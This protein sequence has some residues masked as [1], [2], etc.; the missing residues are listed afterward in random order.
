MYDLD[1]RVEQ[2]EERKNQF[3][4]I[5][6]SS[7]AFPWPC[8]SAQFSFVLSVLYAQLNATPAQ[9]TNQSLVTVVTAASSRTD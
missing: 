2:K 6:L 3:L 8:M 9:L 5:F 7:T 1:L 4:S